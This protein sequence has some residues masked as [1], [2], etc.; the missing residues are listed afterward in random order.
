[1]E[2]KN[3]SATLND[4]NMSFKDAMIQEMLMPVAPPDANKTTNNLS[5]GANEGRDDGTYTANNSNGTRS[6]GDLAS[7]D[8]ADNSTL[9]SPESR[10]GVYRKLYEQPRIHV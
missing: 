9:Q 8:A 3:F 5:P 2:T 4:R 6:G 1:M 7:K 10:T